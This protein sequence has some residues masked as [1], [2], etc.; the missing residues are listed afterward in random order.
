MKRQIIRINYIVIVSSLTIIFNVHG[1]RCQE[2][3]NM[4]NNQHQSNNIQLSD[5]EDNGDDLKDD[6]NARVE[7]LDLLIRRNLSH[8]YQK[9]NSEE[10]EDRLERRTK[11]GGE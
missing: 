7:I 3:S 10:L 1:L 5:R 2:N 9:L 11:I 6:K 8:Q 4:I